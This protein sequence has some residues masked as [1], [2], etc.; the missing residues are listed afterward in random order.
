[1]QLSWNEICICTWIE[2]TE[3]LLDMFSTVSVQMIQ[4]N[5]Y[6]LSIFIDIQ[7]WFSVRLLNHKCMALYYMQHCQA[8][9][10]VCMRLISLF[11]FNNEIVSFLMHYFKQITKK[12]GTKIQN[13]ASWSSIN[14]HCRC[15]F[16]AFVLVAIETFSLILL[17]KGCNFWPILISNE[18]W[19]FVG[20]PYVLW[21]RSSGLFL[22]SF[23]KT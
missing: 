5:D 22:W 7:L 19:G 10:D 9:F 16:L 3:M 12:R 6:A 15:L 14:K 4:L 17:I 20:R 23:P 18:Q 21:Q 2:M 11:T 13:K 1:M 8:M